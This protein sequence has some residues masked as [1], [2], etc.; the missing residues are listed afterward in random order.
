MFCN[1]S[2]PPLCQVSMF[3]TSPI[4]RKCDITERTCKLLRHTIALEE[5]DRNCLQLSYALF[6]GLIHISLTFSER[7]VGTALS[8]RDKNH[9][10]A[11]ISRTT[12]FKRSIWKWQRRHFRKLLEVARFSLRDVTMAKIVRTNKLPGSPPPPGLAL[13][14][15]FTGFILSYAQEQRVKT[16]RRKAI[17]TGKF[18]QLERQLN[19]R[20]GLL[21]PSFLPGGGTQQKFVTGRLRPEVQPRT[22]LYTIFHEKVTAFVYLLLTNGTLSHTFIPCLELCIPFHCCKCTFLKIGINI[23]QNRKFS[24]LYK[25][26]KFICLPFWALSQTQPYCIPEA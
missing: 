18:Q 14:R 16:P 7:D 13:S 21:L 23:S 6:F 3:K 25:A 15:C 26:M 8:Y 10:G 1:R 4:S 12:N 9:F 11:S 22:F 24:R 20:K 2:N 5:I 19:T 17:L